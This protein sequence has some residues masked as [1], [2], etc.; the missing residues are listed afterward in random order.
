[1]NSPQLAGNWDRAGEREWLTYRFWTPAV[2][3]ANHEISIRQLRNHM[4]A[5]GMP[6][7]GRPRRGVPGGGVRLSKAASEWLRFYRAVTGDG[8]F[9]FTRLYE[10]QLE[11]IADQHAEDSQAYARL[12]GGDIP[13]DEYI[14]NH[15]DERR[16]WKKF[17]EI[18]AS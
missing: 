16:S 14:A 6:F 11:T 7:H 18:K 3:A 2:F 5:N 12:Y 8:R 1:M 4:Q 15:A 9:R 17:K 13:Y 10:D